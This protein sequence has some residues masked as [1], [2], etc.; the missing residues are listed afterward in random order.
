MR[1]SIKKQLSFS[2]LFITTGTFLMCWF[3]NL[4]F[5]ELYY[6]QTRKQTLQDTYEIIDDWSRNGDINSEE[7]DDTLL[8]IC[9]TYNIEFI[10]ADA[11]ANIIKT[12]MSDYEE[13]LS[14]LQNA[15]VA[16]MEEATDADGEGAYIIT[17]VLDEE[18]AI[19][20]LVM[21]G[22]L[23]DGNFFMLR[24]SL[25]G[26]RD[27][28]HLANGFMFNVGT[29]I[30]VISS[31]VILLISK[32]ISDPILE[33]TK[34]SERM[35]K[36]DFDAKYTKRGDNEI[37][38][39]GSN[40]NKMSETLE[41]TIRQL[42]NANL[43]LQKD[44]ENKTRIDNLRKEFLANVSH[45][46]KTPIALIQGYAEGLKENVSDDPEQREFYLDVIMDETMKMNQMVKK[47]MTLNQLEFGEDKPEME[48]FNV[49]SL[50]EYFIQS[51]EII[52]KQKGIEV[53]FE[54]PS[55]VY[56]W[57]DEYMTEE[58]FR[59]YFNNAIQYADGDKQIR[60]SVTP[61]EDVGKVRIGVFNTGRR[62][63]EDVKKRLWDKFYKA[64][65]ARSREYGGSGIGLSIVKAMMEAMGQAFGV[66]NKENG[67]EFWFELETK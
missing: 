21:W 54:E 29:A 55:P 43:E 53:I 65:K 13:F 26:I 12:S 59:N 16:R 4:L 3:V 52:T 34:I 57:A 42:K 60:V 5:F 20:Y 19:E 44:V 25:E 8:R 66:E 49:V 46:L 50:L 18:R 6:M 23:G 1:H 35:A 61:L 9:S 41:E 56:V 15:V 45:E 51:S 27:N 38:V 58:V 10:I 14:Q 33:L 67:V 28:A 31:L 7:F 11:G 62:I 48:Y 2:F 36:L 47:L 37:D 40:F 39:L 17:N 64:D 63:D 30:V 32:K 24:T 22:K